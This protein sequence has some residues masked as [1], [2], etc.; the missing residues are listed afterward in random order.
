M[1]LNWFL[2]APRWFQ[3]D[4]LNLNLEVAYGAVIR[5]KN[6]VLEGQ[7]LHS[8][9]QLY[10]VGARQQQITTVYIRD[11]NNRWFIKRHNQTSPLWNATDPI[12][13]VRN[14]DLVR[15]EHR[16]T[17]RNIHVHRGPAPISNKMYQVTGFG[18]VSL[19]FYYIHHPIKSFVKFSFRLKR[20]AKVTTMISGESKLKVLQKAKF[21]K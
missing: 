13:F 17:G 10:P 8:H 19:W 14:G 9:R 11:P 6:N 16:T 5:L 12:D 18:V 15:I 20:K 3:N 21:W 7:Y 1:F 2:Y 4:I